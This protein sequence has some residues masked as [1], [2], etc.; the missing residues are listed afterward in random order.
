MTVNPDLLLNHSLTVLRPTETV[1]NG[2][3][4]LTYSSTT[5][6]AQA[7]SVQPITPAE[8]Q[9][10]WGVEERGTHQVFFNS[11]APMLI[12][13]LLKQASGPYPSGM[14]WWV[15]GLL[16]YNYPGG[17][18]LRGLLEATQQSTS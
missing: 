5:V 2:V 18:H 13:D 12:G 15:R 14:K 1:T 8:V 3:T 16:P 10:D 6:A 11:T 9:R 17:E 7:A 4:V